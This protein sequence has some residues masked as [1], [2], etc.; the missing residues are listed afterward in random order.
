MRF[1]LTFWYATLLAL[2]LFIFSSVALATEKQNYVVALNDNLRTRLAQIASTYDAQKGLPSSLLLS[3]I[4]A[5][6]GT[7][8]GKE[9][10]QGKSLANNEVVLLVTPQGQPVQKSEG[11]SG[12]NASQMAAMLKEDFAQWQGKQRAYPDDASRGQPMG[13]AGNRMQVDDLENTVLSSLT[14]GDYGFMQGVIVNQ[15]GQAVALLAVGI[16]WAGPFLLNDLSSILALAA[17]LC[18]L[19]SG[20]GGYWLAGRTLRPVQ[21]IPRTAQEIS[22]TDLHRR[23]N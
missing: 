8:P 10:V 9:V 20:V 7:L 14:D 11:V 6:P 15:Q 1:R 19:L 22:E 3:S 4:G 21:T 23:L 16:I 18:L 5:V 13:P 2:I 17:P 12:D